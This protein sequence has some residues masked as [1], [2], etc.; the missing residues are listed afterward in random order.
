MGQ[1]GQGGGGHDAG[2]RPPGG[3]YGAAPPTAPLESWEQLQQ[4]APQ[5]LDRL[6]AAPALMLAAAANPLLA[7]EE[8]GYAIAPAVRQDFSDRLR[9]GAGGAL[10]LR[11]LRERIFEHAGHPFDLESAAELQGVLFA[12]LRLAPAPAPSPAKAAAGPPDLGPLP[13]RTRF[14]ASGSAAAGAPAA[15]AD[16]LAALGLKHPIITPLLE[17]RSLEASQPRLA[18][19]EL[20]DE[21]RQGRHAVPIT[22]L[23]ARL[24]SASA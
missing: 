13:V 4:Q 14:G 1:G 16:P 19:R 8:L 7:L 11:R 22:S 2:D 5:L 23:V 24:Q 20:W 17:Y 15:A 21:I 9:F 3:A 10:R 12:E 18:S 6:H